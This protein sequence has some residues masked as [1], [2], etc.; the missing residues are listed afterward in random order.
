MSNATTSRRIGFIGARMDPRSQRRLAGYRAAMEA[1]GLFDL[2][3]VTTSAQPSSVTLGREM[4]RDALARVPTLDAPAVLRDAVGR[5]EVLQVPVPLLEGQRRV[6][7]ADRAILEHDVALVR[8]AEHGARADLERARE[9]GPGE[10]E[11]ARARRV[12]TLD[13]VPCLGPDR[14]PTLQAQK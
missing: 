2:R 3:L 12:T 9:I 1:A 11:E 4:F 14:S 7:A 6:L 8:A 5:A 13:L 10:D